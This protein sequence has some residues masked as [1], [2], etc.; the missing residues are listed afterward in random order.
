MIKLVE[1]YRS[2]IYVTEITF[3][4]LGPTK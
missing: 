1:T 4:C 3:Q 2:A